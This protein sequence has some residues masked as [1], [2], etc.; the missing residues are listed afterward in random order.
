MDSYN[1]ENTV[2]YI[3]KCNKTNQLAIGYD[4]GSIELC[5]MSK[6]EMNVTFKGH[7]S[8]ITCLSFDNDGVNLIS[9]INYNIF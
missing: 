6:N 3:A 9:G 5:D 4:N 2:T 1:S 7:R 8:T